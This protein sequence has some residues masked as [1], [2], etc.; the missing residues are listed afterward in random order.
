MD[1]FRFREKHTPQTECGHHRGRVQQQNVAWLIFIGWVIS[2]ASEWEDYFNY[3]GDMVQISGNWATTHS[4][5]F[6]QCLGTVMAPLGMSFSFLIED[7]GL[8][9]VDLYAM[10]DPFDSIP[11]C[12]VLGL[13]H[14]FKNCALPLSLLLPNFHFS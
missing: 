5:V 7:Q 11:L 9:K 13:C 10:L 3:L 6:R 8:I 1:L 2:F 14:S 4:L 12:S